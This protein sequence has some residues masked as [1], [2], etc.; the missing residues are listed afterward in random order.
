MASWIKRNDNWLP[1]QPREKANDEPSPTPKKDAE[2]IVSPPMQYGIIYYPLRC[3]RCK[4]TEIKTHTSKPPIRYH[5]CRKCDYNFRSIEATDDP[6]K[7]Q[8][9]E[10]V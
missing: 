5:K 10:F 8:I 4:S 2:K 7:K 6:P 1:R 9:P 3:P